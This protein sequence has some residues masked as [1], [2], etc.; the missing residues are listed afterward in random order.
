MIIIK[1][2]MN[3]NNLKKCRIGFVLML[4]KNRIQ[5]ITHTMLKI[6]KFGQRLSV[7][8]RTILTNYP[9]KSPFGT[10]QIVTT[11]FHSDCCY[12]SKDDSSKSKDEDPLKKVTPTIASRYELFN[13]DKASIILDVEEERDKLLAGEMEI[14]VI[15]DTTPNAFA[16][17]NTE[18]MI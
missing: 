5:R 13:E 14:E 11:Y 12:R 7:Q 4:L 3:G 1:L 6:V 17:L 10:Q 18:R 9:V 2:Q 16:G 8:Y 15:E